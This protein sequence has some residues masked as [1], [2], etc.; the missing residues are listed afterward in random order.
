MGFGVFMPVANDG[1]IISAA[2]PKYRPTF[3]LNSGIR[4]RGVVHPALPAG[5][6]R[7]NIDQPHYSPTVTGM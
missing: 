5:V 4:T 6:L 3:E 2:S 7:L 1:W